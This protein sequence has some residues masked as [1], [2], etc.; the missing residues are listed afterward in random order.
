MGESPRR[1]CVIRLHW[2]SFQP[3]SRPRQCCLERQ[4]PTRLW[5]GNQ[6]MPRYTEAVWLQLRL[7]MRDLRKVCPTQVRLPIEGER[8][9][10][11]AVRALVGIAP[12]CKRPRQPTRIRK[13]LGL[14]AGR[15]LHPAAESA[16]CTW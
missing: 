4:P 15:D 5:T 12:P 3:N 6:R 13:A 16:A 10:E 11:S 8:R 14:E 9:L 1:P 7:R 2:R